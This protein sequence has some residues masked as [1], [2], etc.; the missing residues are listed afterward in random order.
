MICAQIDSIKATLHFLECKKKLDDKAAVLLLSNLS[1]ADRMCGLK[2][3]LDNPSNETLQAVIRFMT[4][5]KALKD[6]T[7]FFS[8]HCRLDPSR[9]KSIKALDKLISELTPED[10]E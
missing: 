3:H 7:I 6:I 8:E 10:M 1:P 9:Y 2:L 5:R 4:G